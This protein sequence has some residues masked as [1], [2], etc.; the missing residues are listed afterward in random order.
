MTNDSNHRSVRTSLRE[1]EIRDALRDYPPVM[2]LQAA[3]RLT[4]LAPS[5]LYHWVSTGKLRACVKRGRPL[6]FFRD[7]L[8]REV[9]RDSG[10]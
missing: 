7:R 9:F 2:G 5:T 8:V 10:R 3:S 6:L 1:D 4:G